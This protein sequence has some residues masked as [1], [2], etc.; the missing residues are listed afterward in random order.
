MKR[1]FYGIQKKIVLATTIISGLLF[2]VTYLGINQVVKKDL[3]ELLSRQ[4]SHTNEKVQDAFENTL[5]ELNDLTANF[6]LNEYVQKSLTNQRFL[7]SDKEMMKKSL[8]YQNRSFLDYY[9]IIDNKGNMYGSRDVEID[10]Q[11]FKTSKI[12]QS[13]QEEYSITRILWTED[14]LFGSGKKSFFAI[15]Y[16]HEMNSVHE[17]GILVLKLNDNILDEI[18]E[19]IYDDQLYYFILDTEGEIC[20]SQQPESNFR[21]INDRQTLDSL[22]R[23]TD[24]RKNLQD[25][26]LNRRYNKESGFTLI[27]YAPE[28]VSNAMIKDIQFVMAVIFSA[29]YLAT[30]AAII[31]FTRKYV[32]PIKQLSRTMQKFDEEHLEEKIQLHTNTEL[33]DIGSAY[34]NM[35]DTVKNLMV[36]VQKKE[37]DL[38]DSELQS[39]LYQIRPHFLYNTLDNIHMLARIQKEETIVKMIQ[40]LSRFLRINLSNGKEKIPLEKELEHV[41]SY[42]E[43]QKIRNAELFDYEISC[44]EG[45]SELPVMKMILQPIAEN[46][47]KYGFQ[48]IYEGGMIRIRAYREETNLCFCVANNGTPIEEAKLEKL[49]QLE[50]LPLEQIDAQIQE[51]NGGYGISNVVKRLRMRYEKGIRFY[52]VSTEEETKCVIKLP[53]A[54]LGEEKR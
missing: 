33:D 14:T 20:F 53:L 51:R 31:F 13:L 39:L 36:D 9:L 1:I 2:L 49:N 48:E 32:K 42:L 15:R 7:A 11:T 8:A 23:L 52:Y 25:G 17:P 16:I 41:A 46:A 45:I 34:N 24:G 19:S 22:F 43:I 47:I 38:R 21:T 3:Y 5:E 12:A 35:L 27:T 10:Y 6:I 30:L 28:E 26:I 50:Q 44:E 18:R 37:Q 4:Y 54:E 29:A 40:A